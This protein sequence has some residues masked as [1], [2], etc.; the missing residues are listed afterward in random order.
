MASGAMERGPGARRWAAGRPRRAQVG[1]GRCCLVHPWR[2][3]LRAKQPQRQHTGVGASY[4]LEA[5]VGA[6]LTHGC[7]CCAC[8]VFCVAHEAARREEHILERDRRPLALCRDGDAPSMVLLHVDV[9]GARAERW[10]IAPCWQL[11]ISPLATTFRWQLLPA[12][13]PLHRLFA[14]EHDEAHGLGQWE[15]CELC[16]DTAVEREPARGSSIATRRLVLLGA[17]L[18]AAARLRE[19][20]VPVVVVDGARGC[21]HHDRALRRAIGDSLEA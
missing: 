18:G 6:P 9:G 17:V 14:P 3:G 15:R 4:Q 21:R 12:T 16:G 10:E 1:D 7:A 13:L 19:V 2:T 8:G 11:L 5:A 20:P